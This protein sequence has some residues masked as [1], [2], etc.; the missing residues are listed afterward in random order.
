[1]TE[2]EKIELSKRVAEKYA[3]KP[4]SGYL[5]EANIQ[6]GMT[7]RWD[8]TSYGHDLVVGWLYQD[9]ARTMELAIEHEIDIWYEETVYGECVGARPQENGGLCEYYS[10]HPSKKEA[11]LVA[12]LR[13]L[14]AKK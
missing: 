8:L 3:V 4:P 6:A 2:Q 11:V 10:D 1:M 9:T 5:P 13:T 7:E 12:I 14:E